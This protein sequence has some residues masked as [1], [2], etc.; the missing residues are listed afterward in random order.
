[1]QPVCLNQ[2]HTP[3]ISSY[4][5]SPKTLHFLHTPNQNASSQIHWFHGCFSEVCFEAHTPTLSQFMVQSSQKS[6]AIWVPF[7][8]P[9]SQNAQPTAL[10]VPP[11]LQMQPRKQSIS[12][13][14]LWLKRC[15]FELLQ[16][17]LFFPL[18]HACC[19]R[20]WQPFSSH[21]PASFMANSLSF[22]LGRQI[23]SYDFRFLLWP[24]N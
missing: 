17:L 9:I 15:T 24:P 18:L 3:S 13:S 19:L 16:K 14:C 2:I 22:G 4:K 20:R 8:K 7:Y 11:R 21:N 6:E 12:N 1:M 5:F 23:Q 10:V